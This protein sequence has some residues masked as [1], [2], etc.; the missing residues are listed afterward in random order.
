M[1]MIMF[2]PPTLKCAAI[3]ALADFDG[4]PGGK[5]GTNGNEADD[6]LASFS[7]FSTS[8]IG[9][10]QVVS[11]GAAIDFAAPGVDIYSTYKGGGYKTLS[12]TSMASPHAVGCVALYIARH[13]RAHNAS[14]VAAIRQALIDRAEPQA[15]WGPR[16]TRDPDRNREGLVDAEAIDR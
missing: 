14:E 2:L 6:T 15:A 9:E 4:H 16:D 10:S 1:K 8:V 11:P 7:N 5:G 13:G 12:G 3:S